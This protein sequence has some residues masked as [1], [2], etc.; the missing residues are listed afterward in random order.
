MFSEPYK[1]YVLV[2]MTAVYTLNLV[3]R[4]LIMLLLQPIKEDLLLTDTQ[5]GLLTGIAFGLF[6]AVLGLPIARW[7]DRGNRV[8]ITASAIGLWGLTVMSCMFVTSYVH[9]VCARIAAAVG[10]SGCKPPTYSLVGD[11]FRHPTELTA[12]M[13]V[14]WLG[15]PLSA[16]ISFIIGGW[17]NELYGWRMTFL[18]MGIPGLILAALVKR[19]IREPREHV[20]RARGEERPLPGMSTVLRVLWRQRAC[21]HICIALVLLYTLG[22][23]LNPWY[24]AFLM[25]SHGMGNAEVGVWLGLIIGLSGVVGILLG[26]YVANRWFPGDESGQMRMSAWTVALLVPCFVA[27]LLS[28]REY[29]A[30][31]AL[32]PLMMVF[33]C[34]FAP[35][36]AVM[37]RLVIEEMRATTLAVVMLAANLI[38]MGVGPLIVGMLSDLMMPVLGG[39]ALRYAMLSMSLVALWSGYHFWRAGQ[40]VTDDLA[41]IARPQSALQSSLAVASA[42]VALK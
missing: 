18:I 31:I 39:E 30:L 3:D 27:F 29:Q 22:M 21:R 17:L 2:V 41:R 40:F 26:G 6:Y 4:G 11:Y 32:T 10:E 25:R 14:Y 15:S 12:A 36:Y 23:G 20:R 7:A 42:S 24:A 38:G 13:S 34:Y 5:L 9:I 1:R 8:T 28:P 19:T 35:T 33:S 37:Q 16:L